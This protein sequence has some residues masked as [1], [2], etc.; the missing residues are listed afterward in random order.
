VGGTNQLCCGTGK[1]HLSTKVIP[2]IGRGDGRSFTTVAKASSTVK[3]ESETAP[4]DSL[5]SAV[6][7]MNSYQ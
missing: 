2:R 1:Q 6:K 5:Q 3:R 4:D 7:G